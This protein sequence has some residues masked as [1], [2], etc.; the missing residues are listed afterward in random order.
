M[1]VFAGSEQADA[2]TMMLLR[3]FGCPF[4]NDQDIV[5]LYTPE[6]IAALEWMKDSYDKG[7]FPKNAPTLASLE[8]T[9]LFVQGKVGISFSN[10]V[11]FH[12]MEAKVKENGYEE[13]PMGLATIPQENTGQLMYTYITGCTVFDNQDSEK[14]EV[15][16]DFVK[17][18]CTDEKLIQASAN[19]IP[20]RKS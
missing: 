11:L 20:V 15:A 1:N 5:E 4:I 14:I 10:T 7:Y 13:F 3:M 2:Y 9:D 19:G 8:A 18:V 17:F 6:G 16:K 12:D